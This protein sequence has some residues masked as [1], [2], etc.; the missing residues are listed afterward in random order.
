VRTAT[1]TIEKTDIL[2]KK[3]KTEVEAMKYCKKNR[4]K[5]IDIYDVTK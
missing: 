5:V 4:L 2:K 1:P 3:F